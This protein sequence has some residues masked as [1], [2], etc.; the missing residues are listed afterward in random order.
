MMGI[1]LVLLGATVLINRSVQADSDDSDNSRLL[2]RSKIAY[3]SKGRRDP[4]VQPRINNYHHLLGQVD[5]ESLKLTGIIRNDQ[6]ATALFT[7]QTGPRFGYLLKQGKLYR[8]NHQPVTGITG[9]VINPKQVVLRQG[10]R[11]II[12]K[13]R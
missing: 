7:T 2:V 6:Q 1:L 13:L 11:E 5:I 10:E 8:E 12:F 9:D 3:H 4:F